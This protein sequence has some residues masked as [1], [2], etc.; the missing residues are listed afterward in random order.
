MFNQRNQKEGERI[1]NFVSELKRLS[2]TCE[3]GDLK[4]SLIRDRI[5]GGVLSDELRGE[6]LKKPDLTLQSAHDYCRTFEAA[7]QQKFKF[8][9]PTSAGTER[10]SGIQ[11]VRKSNG[12]GKATA[13][14]CKFC[15]YKHPFTQP[16]KCPA[17]GKK[18]M[19]CRK[20]GHF[21]Q[22]CKEI[23]K[24]GSQV[25]TVEQDNCFD[26]DCQGKSEDVHT[27][28]GSVELGTV[29]DNR[30]RNKSLITLKIA[31]RDIRIK[32][33]TGAEAT[34][35]PYNLYTKLTKKPLQKIHQPLK[36]WLAKKP[37]HPKGSVSLPTQYKNRKLDVLYLVVEGDFTPL[38][39]CDACLD[40]EVIKF[41][42]LQLIDTPEPHVVNPE[43]SRQDEDKSIFK[44]DPVLREYQ[45]CFSDKP[46]KLPTEVHLEIDP[47]VPPVVHP[48][49][50]MPIALLEPAQEKLKEMEEDGIIVKVEEHTPWV[51][52]M[53]V[54][55]K[56][57]AK[58]RDMNIPPSKDDIRICI[59]PRDL[60]KALKRPHY[61][62]VTVEE[63]A[64][65]LSGTTGFT[66][67]D[68]CSGY[69]QL[70]VDDESSKLLTFNTPWGRYRF[71]RL[72]FGISPAPEIYQREMDRLF[73]GVPVQIIVDY[74]LIHG[75]DQRDTDQKLRAVLDKS[76]EVGLKFN[77]H[78]VKLRVPEVN[79]VGHIFSSEGLKPDPFFVGFLL[80]PVFCWFSSLLR[81]VFLRVLRFSPLLKN[82]HF[83]IPIRSGIRGPQVCQ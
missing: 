55:D 40:L 51:S 20:E 34:V 80:V 57:K 69:W 81:E 8:H 12:Q 53:L 6:L 59:D 56:R 33:D 29:S 15:G 74:F 39:G 24:K 54:V 52:S 9:V 50:K 7:E 73:E 23:A 10:S 83:Q 18:C 27:Y 21:A 17:F 76:R 14:W 62:M 67:L 45:D 66:S 47:S 22:V 79:Y 13:R 78:K 28:F 38:L 71:T 68:A 3:F 41:M 43:T 49:R 37:I 63:V 36:G 48:P 30:K 25:D 19:K 61:P 2:L 60:N 75:E 46:G 64:T 32:A 65:R 70:Q 26:E 72:P 77:P 5:V 35:I 1:D 82:Q 58:G 42:N 31:G 44:T 4:D 11:F 16:N